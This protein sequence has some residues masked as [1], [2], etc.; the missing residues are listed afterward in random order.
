[1]ID[2]NLAAILAAP[3]RARSEVIGAIYLDNR[4][5]ESGFTQTHKGLLEVVADQAAI[6][7]ENARLIEDN[8][9]KA[10]ELEKAAKEVAELNSALRAKVERQDREL[11]EVRAQL[12]ASLKPLKHDYPSIITRS[13][14][15]HEVLS[16]IDRV[17]D[18]DAPLHIEGESGTGKELIARAVHDLGIRKQKPF[19]A[20][21]CAAV[22]FELMESEFFGHVRGAFTGADRDKQGLFEVANGGTLFLDEIGEMHLDLQSKFLRVL[23]S[24][25]LR[26]VGDKG[27]RKVDVRIVSATN[28]DLRKLC[29]ESKFREDLYYRIVVI[30]VKLPALR[31]R[32]EDIPLLV[33]RFLARIAE[34][35]RQPRRQASEEALAALNRY[36]WPGNVRQLQNEVE[37]AVALSTEVIRPE[38]FSREVREGLSPLGGPAD[39]DTVEWKTLNLKDIVREASDKVEARAITEAL[40]RAK[41]KSEAAQLLGVS[42]PT[43]DAKIERYEI[44][45][46]RGGGVSD[47]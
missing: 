6:A 47:A 19:V 22:P 30:H 27:S 24:G 35:T 39:G 7:I 18:I 5:R 20:Q 31:E 1:V 17:V 25:E 3:L 14:R 37:R 8:R 46:K 21:N 26:R 28:K 42:R 41:T 40:R 13:P 15:M 34:R 23:Q 16:V 44:P 33:D 29:R 36:P 32:M 2:L 4:F 45:W 10:I 9:R 11:E 43:L 12:G 38:H